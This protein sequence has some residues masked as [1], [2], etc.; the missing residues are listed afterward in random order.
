MTRRD[1]FTNDE[2]SAGRHARATADDDG[3]EGLSRSDLGRADAEL[4]AWE[5]QH[6][7][8]GDDPWGAA[9]GGAR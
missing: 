1:D 9:L 8:D 2:I 5:A 7:P 3:R 6:T 4:M